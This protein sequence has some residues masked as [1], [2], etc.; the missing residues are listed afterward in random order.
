MILSGLTLAAFATYAAFGAGLVVAV[1]LA[2]II[3][4]MCSVGIMRSFGTMV[5]EDRPAV[6]RQTV[7]VENDDIEYKTF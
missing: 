7:K 3:L 5:D 1:I 2:V 4:V 6:V